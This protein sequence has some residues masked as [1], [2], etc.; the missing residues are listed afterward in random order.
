MR[1]VPHAGHVFP[2]VIETDRLRLERCSRE[3]VSTRA[4][5][6]AAGRSQTI[7]AETAYLPWSPLD[8]LADAEERLAEFEQQWEERERA[9]WIVRPQNGEPGAGKFA[10]TAGL[11]CRWDQYLALLAIWLQ[12]PFWGR[13]YSGEHADALLEVAFDRLDAGVAAVPIHGEND[14]SYAAVEQYVDRHGGR[15]E[16][17]LQN[18]AGRYEEPADHHR[19]S[20]SHEEWLA[21]DGAE[22]AVRFPGVETDA[23]SLSGR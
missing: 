2:E 19:F 15:Y 5:Y 18:H 1:A 9:E 3:H 20:V 14:R 12:K 8:T 17:R 7:D 11:I 4:L 22:T 13:G 16:G 23:D 21:A 6:D 10:G